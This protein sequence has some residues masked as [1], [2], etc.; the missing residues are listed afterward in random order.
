LL[1]DEE[2]QQEGEARVHD[3]VVMKA[4]GELDEDRIHGSDSI[5][6]MVAMNVD[7][8]TTSVDARGSLRGVRRVVGLMY[9]AA[10]VGACFLV[11]VLFSENRPYLLDLLSHF[12]P[13][14][15]VVLVVVGV[16]GVM[17]R[18]RIA[19]I[20]F[21]LCGLVLLMGSRL[22]VQ[23]PIGAGAAAEGYVR[24]KLVH[25]NAYGEKSRHDNEF[26]AWLRDQDADL[27]VIVDS[28]W[29]YVH[30]QPWLK[31]KYPAIVQPS[32]GLEWP[33]LL[34]SRHPAEIKA[35]VPYSEETK[36]S[37]VARRNLLITLEE[38]SKLLLTAQ[39]PPSPRKA[40]FVAMA[41]KNV[42]L[43]GALLREW[44]ARE[45]I[46][47]IV[48]GDFNSSPTG[49]V[50]RAFRRASGLTG[51]SPLILS[52]TWPA[53]LPSWLGVPIDRVCTGG[54]VQVRSVAVGPRFRSDHRPLVVE[55]DVPL[56][57]AGA[58]V[59]P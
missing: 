19:A 43:D 48:A 42:K 57:H 1:K 31:E 49:T 39:H 37:F 25:Y 10:A 11:V 21:V 13:L 55:L 26:N 58:G 3:P 28:V 35:L 40:K 52:G 5:V 51:W 32:A 9:R 20:S 36:F 6:L 27:V 54:G 44:L 4:C 15:G 24:L 30:D 18:Q 29:G 56:G 8:S 41:V 14:A 53:A 38:G 17:T 50:H 16:I 34:M 2:E 7:V 12:L 46:P 33:V 45:Q 59:S 47:V 23:R 22:W